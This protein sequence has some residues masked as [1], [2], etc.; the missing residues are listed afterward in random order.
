MQFVFSCV[1][2]PRRSERKGKDVGQQQ[3]AVLTTNTISGSNYERPHVNEGHY[4][5]FIRWVLGQSGDI[6]EG[7]EGKACEAASAPRKGKSLVGP[8]VGGLW[9]GFEGSTLRISGRIQ[10]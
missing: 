5:A 9:P 10:L 8:W 2:E 4:G 6:T 7:V 1:A 3:T